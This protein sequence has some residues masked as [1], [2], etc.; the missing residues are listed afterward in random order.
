[1]NKQMN[2]AWH[3]K[4]GDRFYHP[5]RISRYGLRRVL[6]VSALFSVGYGNVGSS[7]Y[8][9]LGI[10]ALVALGATPI[11]LG[12]AGVIY[13]FNALTYAEG[14]AMLPEAGGSASFARHG[15]NDAIGF[16]AGWA[17]MLSYIATVAISAYTIPPYLAYFWPIL[18][19]PVIGTTVSIGIIGFL[20]LVNIFGVR[21]SSR[22]NTFFILI[23]IAALITLIILGIVLILGPNPT[24]LF[25]NMF[26][27][28]NWPSTQNLI[29]GI[30]IAA[31]C[32]T[33]VETV[34]QLAQETRQPEKR[35]PQAY[36]LMIV[37]VLILFA[38]I[39]IVALSAMTP[40]ELTNDWAR[41]PVAGIAH[42]IS[43]AI[44]P[45]KLATG[46]TTEPALVIVLTWLF[47]G[48]HTLLP[49]LVASLAA[50]ILLTATNAGVMGI[51]RLAFNMSSHRQLP[52]GLSRIHH[53][54]RTPHVAIIIFC[55]AAL[56]LLIP[57]FFNPLF[58]EDLG[59]IYVFGSLFAFALAHAAILALRIRKP[60]L[61]RP[62]KLRGNLRIRG[63]E[64]PITAILGLTTTLAVWLVVMITQP[65]SRWAG[66]TWM[67]LGLIIYFAYRRTQH[68]PLAH[69]KETSTPRDEQNQLGKG[70]GTGQ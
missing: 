43:L 65:Y 31:L 59:A 70:N 44:T 57:D 42:S 68:L 32:F 20:M 16:I 3:H 60:E 26:G 56:L 6:G 41:D 45:E 62:F 35:I 49:I 34:S 54:F 37:V 27:E 9:A 47:E 28:G 8:Y 25:Q 13:I 40:Q 10:I 5:R 55:L 63:R 33:G 2:N 38:G 53:R 51:S 18:K 23:D 36:I 24:A 61:H 22:L 7:I 12:I 48:I 4:P 11:V 50:T 19:E 64:L 66:I 67:V 52:I 15:F 69:I 17:L 39:S 30:A 58:F 14:T 46:I 1:M 29:Y 21:E